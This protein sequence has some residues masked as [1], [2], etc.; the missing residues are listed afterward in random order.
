MGKQIMLPPAKKAEI[1]KMF[2]TTRVTLWSALR[3]DTNSP[4]AKKLRAAAMVRGGVIYE[5]VAKE[6]TEDVTDCIDDIDDEY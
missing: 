4:L 5:E 1:V 6:V 2:G 3:F